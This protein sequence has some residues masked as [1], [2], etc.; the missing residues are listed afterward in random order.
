MENLEQ[1]TT[2][3]EALKTRASEL[4]EKAEKGDQPVAEVK[5]LIDNEIKPQLDVLTKDREIALQAEEVKALNGTVTDL[6][7]VIEELRKPSAGF[8]IGSVKEEGKGSRRRSLLR[9]ERQFKRSV[10]ADVKL[11]NAVT[12]RTRASA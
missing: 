8:A 11:A 1:I 12:P 6:S 5:A 9:R 4:L 7:K 2:K 10:Y 3:I